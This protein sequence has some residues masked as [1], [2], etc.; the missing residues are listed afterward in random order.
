MP[1]DSDSDARDTHGR[2]TSEYA[3]EEILKAVREHAPASTKEIADAVGC[4]R[5]NADRRL[6]QLRERGAVASKKT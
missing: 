6:R 3:D 2:Y 1:T 4:S 5:Q